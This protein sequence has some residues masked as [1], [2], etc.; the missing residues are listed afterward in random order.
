MNDQP[1]NQPLR[2]QDKADPF[3]LE[4]QNFL[5]AVGGTATAINSAQ[6]AIYL[7]GMLDA[8]HLSSRSRRQEVSI[9]RA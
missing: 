3:E 9:A 4:M 8:I 5:D 2:P 1:V 7:M 6:Q